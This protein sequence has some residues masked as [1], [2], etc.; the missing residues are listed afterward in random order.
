MFG[1][2]L[3]CATGSLM[4]LGTRANSG[5]ASQLPT[6]GELS[7]SVRGAVTAPGQRVYQVLY[8][9][10]QSFCTPDS[11]NLSNALLVTWVP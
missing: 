4:R 3:I 2:G 6:Q 9:N 7:I 10:T 5:G 1:D 8:R 11:F